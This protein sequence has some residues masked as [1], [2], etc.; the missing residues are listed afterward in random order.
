[1]NPIILGIIKATFSQ[2]PSFVSEIEQT[3]KDIEDPAAAGAKVKKLIQD[4]IDVLDTLA[5]AL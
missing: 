2:L 1:M 4:G 5:K 3:V